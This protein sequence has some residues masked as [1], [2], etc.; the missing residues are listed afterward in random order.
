MVLEQIIAIVVFVLVLV[1]VWGI[2]KKLF[3]VLFYAGIIIFLLIAANTYFLYKDVMDLRENFGVAEKKVILA[4]EG[5][6]LT[7]LLLNDETNFLTASQLEEFSSYLENDDYEKILGDSYK[8]MIFD[9]DII[10]DIDGEIDIG[11]ETITKEHAISVLNS[12]ADAREKA[13]LFG[14]VL[15]G[16]ILSS[17]NPLFFFSEFKKGNIVIYP[18]TALFKTIKII[19]LPFIKDVGKKMFEKTKEK[20][21]TFVVEE[22]EN[23]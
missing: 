21:K 23:I 10:S 8:F 19:P 16:N 2:F 13:A 17:K 4:D 20:V 18:E 14:A 6:V 9:L 22:S 1:F 11:D 12:N 5:R 15:S 3:K 7:G